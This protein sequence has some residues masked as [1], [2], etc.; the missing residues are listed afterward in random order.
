MNSYIVYWFIWGDI[1]DPTE[2]I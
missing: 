2:R 1:P